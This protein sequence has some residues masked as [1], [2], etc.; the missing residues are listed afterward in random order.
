MSNFSYN[1][2]I[3]EKQNFETELNKFKTTYEKY[4]T[5]TDSSFITLQNINNSS[6]TLIETSSNI[7]SNILSNTDCKALC[8]ANSECIA[9]SFLDGSCNTYKQLSSNLNYVDS[10]TNINL[11][12]N[13]DNIKKIG[14]YLVS[15]NENIIQIAEN[16]K[17][18]LNNYETD[19]TT[20]YFY[21][22]SDGDK[23]KLDE[24]YNDLQEIQQEKRNLLATHETNMDPIGVK[25]QYFRYMFLFVLM[26]IML[27]VF[28]Y[29]TVDNT[30]TDGSNSMIYLVSFVIVFS[31]SIIYFLQ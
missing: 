5:S 31:V 26:F 18:K 29:F 7:L 17:N 20:G 10:N 21:N 1:D 2:F 12:K 13:S 6:F 27:T 4:D 8:S 28:I 3:I 24:N 16:V 25:T 23:L 19:T 15:Q 30:T 14:D 22:E 11:L 9:Y